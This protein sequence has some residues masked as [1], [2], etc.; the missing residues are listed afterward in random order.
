MTWGPVELCQYD[1]GE[2]SGCNSI[3]SNEDLCESDGN[4]LVGSAHL[5]RIDRRVGA[6]CYF[7]GSLPCHFLTLENGLFVC[8]RG[9]R[10]SRFTLGG[11]LHSV[12][13][14]NGRPS[15][16]DG[17]PLQMCDGLSSGPV[18]GFAHNRPF[19]LER[20]GTACKITGEAITP[21]RR[22]L[23]AE[24]RFTF[25]GEHGCE[26]IEMTSEGFVC[27]SAGFPHLWPFADPQR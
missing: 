3:D 27:H 24:G 18:S 10:F 6:T 21:P 20:L 13:N 2:V 17:E 25:P 5:V 23:N 12:V 1:A 19:M 9:A 22:E 11:E 8:Q 16:T 7:N 14:E 26:S 15:P 4:F